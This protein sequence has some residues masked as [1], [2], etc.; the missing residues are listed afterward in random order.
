MTKDTFKTIDI[1]IFSIIA[2]ALEVAIYFS[3]QAFGMDLPV[4]VSFSIVL[5][6][7]AIYRW[8]I[9]GSIVCILGGLASATVQN[10]VGEPNYYL[11]LIYGVG[12][13]CVALS[14]LLLMNGRRKKISSRTLYLLLYELVG[15]L[16]VICGRSL[17]GVIIYHGSFTNYLLA[18]IGPECLGF[19]LGVFVLIFANKPNGVL[20][21]MNEYI[22][23]VQEEIREDKLHLKKIKDSNYYDVSDVTRK[24]M[25]N[26]ASLLDGGNL[27]QNQL[28]E[29]QIMF[30]ES[31]SDDNEGGLLNDGKKD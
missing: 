31:L 20:V 8:G 10:M 17:L 14:Y 27:N 7:I 21:E 23:N 30:D 2:I 1:A 15:Y 22:R 9:L 5:S 18:F 13:A 16:L 4:F 26:D 29:L 12:N 6:L 3:S 24:D 11:F 19:F 28:D 25:I